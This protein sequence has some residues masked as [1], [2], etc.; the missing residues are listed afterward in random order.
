ML[1]SLPTVS[2]A[3]V[4]VTVAFVINGF[5]VGAFNARIPDFKEILAISNGQLGAALLCSAAGLLTALGPTGRICARRG[6]AWVAVPSAIGLAISTVIVGM[7]HAFWQ[8]SVSLFV[9]GFFLAV[10][11]VSMNTHAVAVEHEASKRFMSTFHAMFSLGALIGAF[12]GGLLSQWKITILQHTI[13]ISIITIA[14][15]LYFKS[16]WLPNSIDIHPVEKHKHTRSKRRPAIF[17]ALGL[18]MMCGQVGEGAAG[19]WGG[20]LSRNTFH[21]SPFISTLPYICFAITMVTGR[22]LGDRLATKYGTRKIVITSGLMASLG[23]SSGLLVGGMPGVIAGWI[24]LAAG[25]STVFPLIISMAGK[26]AKGRFADRMA[27]AEGMAMVAGVAY[28]GFLAGPPVI[29]F[30]SNLIGLRWAMMIPAALAFYVF[31]AGY[32]T[33]KE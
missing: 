24:F 6:S 32:F 11:D 26:M 20:V 31:L 10:Q 29:G 17:W 8:L 7:S 25:S 19:D 23:L 18:I 30:V 28:F 16:W 22:F 4:A 27:P 2:R 33:V 15:A 21:A 1:N 5:M 12:T 14:V 13:A 9:F 3:R